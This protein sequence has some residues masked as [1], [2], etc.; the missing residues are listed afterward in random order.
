VIA[1]PAEA[2]CDNAPDWAVELKQQGFTI[3]RNILSTSNVKLLR[4]LITSR[5]TE[6]GR[7][8]SAGTEKSIFLTQLLFASSDTARI[9][10]DL[11]WDSR[12]QWILGAFHERSVIEHTKVLVKASLAP[13]TPWHQDHAF[14]RKYDPTGTMITLWSPL[15]PVGEDNGTLRLLRS[16]PPRVLLPHE[17]A[18]V[19]R[20]KRVHAESLSPLLTEGIVIPEANPGDAVLFTSRAVHGTFANMTDSDRLAFKLVFQDL[21]RRTQQPLRNGAVV[22]HGIEGLL[23][24]L[25][26]CVATRIRLQPDL[27]KRRVKGIWKRNETADRQDPPTSR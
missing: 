2:T 3:V 4:E 1:D 26:P 7:Q 5:L 22:F 21:T 14:F 12:I 17:I 25:Y 13:E 24:R 20:E 8:G 9:V 19:E 10:R 18:N 23:N 6:I 27:L 15:H 11:F 16:K